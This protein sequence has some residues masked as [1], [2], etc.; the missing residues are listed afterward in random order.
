MQQAAIVDLPVP[1]LKIKVMLPVTLVLRKD[2][3][4]R[5]L[6]TSLSLRIIF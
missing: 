2:F 5:L 3:R 4:R 6:S 1:E